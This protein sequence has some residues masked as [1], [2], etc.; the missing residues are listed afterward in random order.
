M[1]DP[2]QDF[3]PNKV[4]INEK[5]VIRNCMAPLIGLGEKYGTA[6]LIVT[7]SNKQY[8]ALKQKKI[9]KSADIWNIGRSVLLVGETGESGI[10]YIAQKKSNYSQLE[11]LCCIV[12]RTKELFS[13]DTMIENIIMRTWYCISELTVVM[14]K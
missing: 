14:Y 12:W 1:F 8:A 10:N 5:N 4:K 11:K 7:H 6:F 2:I 13:R 9:E 3:L